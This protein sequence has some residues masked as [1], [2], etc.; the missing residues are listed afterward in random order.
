MTLPEDPL[1]VPGVDF[2]LR[3][4]RVEDP[5]SVDLR[6]YAWRPQ[7]PTDAR[8]LL[9]VAGWVSAIEGWLDLL[10]ALVPNRAVYYLETRE[11]RS[12]EFAPT[13]PLS[14]ARLNMPR[15]AQDVAAAMAALGLG[16][17]TIVAGSSLGATTLLE[18]L[19]D[20]KLQAAG[21]FLVAPN[22]EFKYPWWGHIIIRLPTPLYVLVKHPLL[23]YLRLFKVKEPQQMRRYQA[24]LV[25]A[26]PARIRL[27]ALGFSGYEVWRG[28]E[29]IRVPVLVA[30]AANDALHKGTEAGRLIEALPS[31]RGLPCPSNTFMH[32]AAV[33]GDFE[34]FAA[35]LGP[36]AAP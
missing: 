25:S 30:Y 16:P 27:S 17:E 28:L 31:A 7:R 1:C 24:T 18:S 20:G 13:L 29:T 9:F 8:P 3:T 36:A 2:E 10:R 14:P 11:K 15:M 35:T 6:V 19:K 12:A 32:S 4:V 33:A 23:L 34:A 22:V 21:A 5:H 26:H